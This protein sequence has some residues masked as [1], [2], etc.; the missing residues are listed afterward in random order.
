MPYHLEGYSL[1]N[2]RERYLKIWRDTVCFMCE[3]GTL[4]LEGYSLLNVRERYLIIWRD[5]VCLMCEK[6]TLS[7]GG[8]QFV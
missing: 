5:T 2:V 8:I 6:G 1:L 7:F 4:S 3:K